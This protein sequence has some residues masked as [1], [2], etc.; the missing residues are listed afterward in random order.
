[1]KLPALL[2]LLLF[3]NC[4]FAQQTT[5]KKETYF[6]ENGNRI[7]ATGFKIK[8]ENYKVFAPSIVSETDST[9]IQKIVFREVYDVLL[10]SERETVVKILQQLTGKTID[11]NQTIVINF[12][13]LEHVENQAPCIDHYTS[14][15]KYQKYFEKHDSN[16]QFF[17]TEKGYTHNKPNL[18]QDTKGYIRNLLF[19]DRLDCGNYVIIKPNG[20]YY[21]RVGEYRQDEIPDRIKADW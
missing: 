4:L 19:K 3:S 2:L 8:Y 10:P 11:N 17:I 6:D 7:G 12:F 15:K 16:I 1:M 9:I 14:D 21:K 18:Y 5:L 13:F 20:H